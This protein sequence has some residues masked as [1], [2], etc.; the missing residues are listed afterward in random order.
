VFQL[1]QGRSFRAVGKQ[2]EDLVRKQAE[3]LVEM[4]VVGLAAQGCLTS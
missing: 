2:A 4:L 1:L 3:D